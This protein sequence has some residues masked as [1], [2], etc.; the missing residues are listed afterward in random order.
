MLKASFSNLIYVVSMILFLIGFYAV[1]MR[2]SLIKKIIGI[3]I[4]ETAIFLFLIG[5]GNKKGGASPLVVEGIEKYV[6]PFPQA[7]VL[8]ALVVGVGTTAL[9]LIL[10]VRLFECENGEKR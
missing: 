10:A 4:M 5:I 1:A 2:P 8:M 7:M 9:A 3:N 6:N